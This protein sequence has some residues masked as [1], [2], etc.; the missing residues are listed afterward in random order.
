MYSHQT[1]KSQRRHID[2]R[3]KPCYLSAYQKP[4]HI[5]ANYEMMNCG[6][7]NVSTVRSM[8][9]SKRP[10]SLVLAGCSTVRTFSREGERMELRQ[11]VVFFPFV[12]TVWIICCFGSGSLSSGSEIV[13]TEIAFAKRYKFLKPR[14]ERTIVSHARMAD[15]WAQ[16]AGGT[17]SGPGATAYAHKKAYMYRCL[18]TECSEALMILQKKRSRWC[19]DF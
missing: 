16:L 11:Y 2:D 8:G 10:R 7:K 18:S 15:V 3:G 12:L 13:Q 9:D 4:I 17:A 19:F 6:G 14:F 1:R 5:G